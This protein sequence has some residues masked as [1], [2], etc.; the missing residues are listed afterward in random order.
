MWW[1]GKKEERRGLPKAVVVGDFEVDA[2]GFVVFLKPICMVCN[3]PLPLFCPLRTSRSLPS[4][5]T[6]HFAHNHEGARAHYPMTMVPPPPVSSL[7]L[8]YSPSF[9]RFAVS[10]SS[11]SAH[12]PPPPPPKMQSPSP[13]RNESLKSSRGPPDASA[14]PSS[15]SFP[16][17]LPSQAASKGG[18]SPLRAAPPVPSDVERTRTPQKRKEEKEAILGLDDLIQELEE[19]KGG[20]GKSSTKVSKGRASAAS[21]EGVKVLSAGECSAQR[22]RRSVEQ[23][24]AFLHFLSTFWR[25]CKANTC[26]FK[27]KS[28]NTF[29]S[30]S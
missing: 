4:R 6:N 5:P 2:V 12:P 21:G 9:F 24:T 30:H 20:P 8:S 27:Q 29:P 7:R 28:T 10:V 15:P 11:P 1:R 3:F 18:G 23:C 25:L 26:A 17:P 14:A 16:P 13:P 19:A 22:K